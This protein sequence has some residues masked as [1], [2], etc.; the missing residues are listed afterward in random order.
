MSSHPSEEAVALYASGDLEAGELNSIAE[1]VRDC[2][3][4]RECVARFQQVAGVLASDAGEPSAE[5]LLDVRQRVMRT[6]ESTRRQRI[7]FRWAAAVAALAAL[8]VLLRHREH[9]AA[10]IHSV[11]ATVATVRA[12]APAPAV[13]AAAVV[14]RH[15]A[16]LRAP[17]LRSVALVTR[18]GEEPLIKIA[19]TDPK[20][21]IL[22][23]P[24]TQDNERTE[25][26]DE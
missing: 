26:N 9:P 22:L 15:R 2:A 10:E 13:K 6:L 19:T 4:C 11:P 25:S 3:G 7:S 16:R 20:V 8:V 23:Q 1:H 24:D 21:V 5:D 14:V 12:P 18:R 17:G